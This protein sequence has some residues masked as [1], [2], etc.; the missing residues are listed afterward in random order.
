M[1]NL[2]NK[3]NNQGKT[4]DEHIRIVEEK[5]HPEIFSEYF[6]YLEDEDALA[7]QVLDIK[8]E[9]ITMALDRA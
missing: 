4:E 7:G 8:R 2:V 1:Y 5:V 6:H 9:L 3:T